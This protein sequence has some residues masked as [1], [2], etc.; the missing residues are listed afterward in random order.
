[1]S[2]DVMATTRVA[3][4]LGAPVRHSRSPALHNAAFAAAGIDAVLVAL[5]VEP[6]D[7]AAAVSGLRAL[8]FLGASV[9]VPHKQAVAALCDRLAGPAD[10]I[11]AVNCLELAR[12]GGV[13]EIIGHNTDAG[14]FVD[15]LARDAGM[16]V[17]GC[18]AV[19]LGAGGAAR[20][21]RAG[22][23]AA[24]A[25]EVSVVARAPAH[26]GWIAALPW[27][28]DTLAAAC[29]R[30]DLLVDCTSSALDADAEAALPSPVPL[31]LV[32]AHA[33][34]ASLIYHRRPALL[35][36]AGA[37]GLRTLDGAGM[38][39]Y[40]GARAFAIWTGA[41]APVEAMWTAMRASLPHG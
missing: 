10:T 24:G 30:C 38:L 2:L 39:V 29:A 20:A 15:S 25:A 14:G 22:L 3:A 8:G 41:A 5:H 33:V 31:E 35:R 11:G 4:V 21:V 7:L 40:Q 36:A 27:T 16:D 9:T 23:V 1:M 13:V 18:R 17:R 37:R 28:A 19:L 32:P 6:A 12:R 26:I 34:V